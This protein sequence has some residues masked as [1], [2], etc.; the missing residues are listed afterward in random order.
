MLSK[1]FVY[2][3][4]L[5]EYWRSLGVFLPCNLWPALISPCWLQFLSLLSR[6]T[7]LHL[8]SYHDFSMLKSRYPWNWFRLARGIG[9]KVVGSC[10][11]LRYDLWERR[12]FI[13]K[14]LSQGV[15]LKK[16]TWKRKV[17]DSSLL[18]TAK[19]THE[20]DEIYK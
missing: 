4:H 8:P 16:F 10:R 6:D 15:V 1:I 12:R 13:F 20:A 9:W 7:S 18:R 2:F 19:T 17:L 14:N 11:K 5:I 3:I